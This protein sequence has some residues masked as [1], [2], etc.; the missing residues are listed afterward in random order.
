MFDN[1]FQRNISKFKISALIKQKHLPMG[2]ENYY[3][4]NYYYLIIIVHNNIFSRLA[5]LSPD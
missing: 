3:Y 5:C 2:Y 1:Y 4:L